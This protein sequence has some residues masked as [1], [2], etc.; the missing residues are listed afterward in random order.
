M[1]AGNNQWRSWDIELYL[2]S[3]TLINSAVCFLSLPFDQNLSSLYLYVFGAAF[4][5]LGVS[6]DSAPSVLSLSRAHRHFLSFGQVFLREF[7]NL[8]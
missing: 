4:F 7:D 6:T 8:F 1:Y 5:I 3:L 2:Q